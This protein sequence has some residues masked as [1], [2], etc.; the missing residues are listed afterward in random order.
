MARQSTLL[1]T[2]ISPDSFNLVE[3]TNATAGIN[4]ATLTAIDPDGGAFTYAIVGG[5]DIANFSLAGAGDE[6]VFTAGV[7]DHETQDVYSVDIRVTDSVGNTYDETISLNVDDINESPTVETS[8]FPSTKDCLTE[9]L[10]DQ[11]SATDLD[12]GVNG[13]LSFTV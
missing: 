7:L 6:L 5:A 3:G 12:D 1:P 8:H 10:L 4:L 9:M 11:S 13:D 2:D